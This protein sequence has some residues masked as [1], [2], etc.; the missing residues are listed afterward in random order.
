[1]GHELGGQNCCHK[2]H[3]YICIYPVVISESL[4]QNQPSKVTYAVDDSGAGI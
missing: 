2:L 3:E 4:T 1:M